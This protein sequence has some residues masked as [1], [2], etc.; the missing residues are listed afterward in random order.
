[1]YAYL[2][3][4]LIAA[5][6]LVALDGAPEDDL[7]ALDAGQRTAVNGRRGDSSEDDDDEDEEGQARNHA[8]HNLVDVGL[9]RLRRRA[10]LMEG[11]H[12]NGDGGEKKLQQKYQSG[13]AAT[14]KEMMGEDESNNE[15]EYEEDGDDSLDDDEDG[16]DVSFGEGTSE[17]E[18]ELLG[19]LEGQSESNGDDEGDVEEQDDTG[20]VSG[21]LS[22]SHAS[23]SAAAEPSSNI[24]YS[25]GKKQLRFADMDGGSHD[26]AEAG[27]SFRKAPATAAE[28]DAALLSDLRQRTRD[29][30][31]RG[32]ETRRSLDAWG[33]LLGVRIR[34]Q[35]VVRN[36]G[37]IPARTMREVTPYLDEDEKSSL[38]ATLA[39]LDQMSAHL[40]RLQRLTLESYGQ[41]AEAEQGLPSLDFL[42]DVE[43]PRKRKLDD[44]EYD[45]HLSNALKMHSGVFVPMWKE[46]LARWAWRTTSRSLDDSHKAK[47]RF[48]SGAGGGA[49]GGGAGLKAMNQSAEDQ[50]ARGLSGDAYERLKKRTRVW[51]GTENEA[52]IVGSVEDSKTGEADTAEASASQHQLAHEDEDIFDDSDFYAALLRELIDSRGRVTG[53][54]GGEGGAAGSFAGA[55]AAA[56]AEWAHAAKRAAKKHRAGVDRKASKGRR[57]RYDVHEK[58]ENFMPPIP[59]ETWSVEQIDR[60]VHQLR[61]SSTSGRDAVPVDGQVNGE[62]E[63]EADILTAPGADVS[64]GGLRLF[65]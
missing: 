34:G 24:S 21:S 63:Q 54:V 39:S 53:D 23:S 61:A 59:R 47:N 58:L 49:S 31:A 36:A 10:N 25:N 19:D 42:R 37:R 2:C 38:N 62:R 30:A 3:L 16:D 46:V 40:F 65:A 48:D 18:N 7:E 20:S 4:F 14:R 29:D 32:R 51:R 26:D 28:A 6:I 13:V 27:S 56:S 44:V 55:G 45:T 41:T 64:L 9:S 17:G 8:R 57:L 1:M 33:K 5:H 11:F 15:D 52:R 35:K 22:A 43:Q 12:G 50:I 60:L